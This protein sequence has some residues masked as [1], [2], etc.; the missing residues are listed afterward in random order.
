MCCLA[1]I[2]GRCIRCYWDLGYCGKMQKGVLIPSSLCLLF[3]LGEQCCP[4]RLPAAAQRS[5][6]EMAS[7]DANGSAKGWRRG[8]EEAGMDGTAGCS[9]TVRTSSPCPSSLVGA[10]RLTVAAEGGLRN[11]ASQGH[12]RT[13]M[14]HRRRQFP[15]LLFPKLPWR[16]P[17]SQ[18]QRGK[19][20][21]G[22]NAAT[23]HRKERP[24]STCTPPQG[25]VGVHVCIQVHLCTLIPYSLQDTFNFNFLVLPGAFPNQL[26]PW[27]TR[28]APCCAQRWAVWGR[29]NLPLRECHLHP[30]VCHRGAPA[31]HKQIP[32]YLLNSIRACL[33][34]RSG[35]NPSTGQRFTPV[36]SGSDATRRGHRGSPMLSTERSVLPQPKSRSEPLCIY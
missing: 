5:P 10:G 6:A 12:G 26:Q 17:D 32:P 15:P 18:L 9:G 1:G 22:T 2:F 11:F 23:V 3:L 34:L 4:A 8:E 28:A 19:E 29:K 36:P 35:V 21:R 25:G 24:S 13:T 30:F 16:L 20:Q 27:L 14:V 33:W 7:I 31:V